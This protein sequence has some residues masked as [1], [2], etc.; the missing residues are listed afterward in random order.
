MPSGFDKQKHSRKKE[1][2]AFTVNI[3]SFIHTSE[4]FTEDT[5]NSK[6]FKN[7]EFEAPKSVFFPKRSNFNNNE[8]QRAE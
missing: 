8:P 5:L 3:F 2:E 6:P 4:E 1:F 7:E